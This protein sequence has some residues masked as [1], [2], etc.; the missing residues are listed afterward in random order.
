MRCGPGVWGDA[1]KEPHSMSQDGMEADGD[2]SPS[3]ILV[4]S[5]QQRE[6]AVFSEM[7]LCI[8]PSYSLA[9]SQLTKAAGQKSHQERQGSKLT[10]TVIAAC[11]GVY[12]LKHGSVQEKHYLKVG[13]SGEAEIGTGDPF[14]PAFRRA[15]K[16]PPCFMLHE[17]A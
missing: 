17:G 13:G 4:C 9:A 1:A 12:F 11:L 15:V 14:F 10:Q 8:W 16:Q 3:R 6:R 2:D 7:P 5:W